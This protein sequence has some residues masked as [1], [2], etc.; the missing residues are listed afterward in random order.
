MT[1]REAIKPVIERIRDLNIK[2]VVVFGSAA[3]GSV[4][5]HSDLDLA[6]V[7]PARAAGESLDRIDVAI[8]VRR[9][10]REINRQLAIDILVY[11]ESE[12][13]HLCEPPSF[14]RGERLETE[15]VVYERAG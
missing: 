1:P 7:V 6:I 5:K 14:V 13:Q 8:T 4:D 15:K 2:R 9:R 11:T 10:L 3:R 12:Y